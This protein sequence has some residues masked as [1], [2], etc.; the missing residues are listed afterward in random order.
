[1]NNLVAI[2]KDRDYYKW[3]MLE[4]NMRNVVLGMLSWKCMECTYMAISVSSYIRQA[5]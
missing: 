3:G 4:R 5:D 1:L 2:K